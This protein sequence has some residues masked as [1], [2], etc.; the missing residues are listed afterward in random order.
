MIH[1]DTS[2]ARMPFFGKAFERLGLKGQ[3]DGQKQPARWERANQ[4]KE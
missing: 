2:R 4:M 3:V 1:L